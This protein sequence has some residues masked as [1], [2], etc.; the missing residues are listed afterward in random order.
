M[1]ELETLKYSPDYFI[2]RHY[3]DDPA[4]AQMYAQERARVMAYVPGGRIFDYGCG[5][6]DFLAGFDPA[7]YERH[8]IDISTFATE[9]AR[10][11]G[12]IIH[13]YAETLSYPDGYFDAVILRGTMQHIY[14][15]FHVLRECARVI[16][17]GGHLIF[18]ATPNT[19]SL[20]YFLFGDLPAF[21]APRNWYQVSDKTLKNIVQNLNFEHLET[22]CPYLGTPYAHPLRDAWRFVLR[23][24]GVVKAFAWPGNMMELYSRK[25]V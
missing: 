1:I 19:R 13:P 20:C 9:Q 14:N 23:L 6:G 5:I 25:K 10:A 18:L 17:P 16:K 3:G 4:R 21:D 11:H 22:R 2:T 12:I 15:P 24:C 8:G 7:R